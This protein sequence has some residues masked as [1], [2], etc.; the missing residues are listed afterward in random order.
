MLA[1]IMSGAVLGIEAYLVEVEVDISFGLTAF[2]IVGLPD[3]AVRE[4]RLRIPSALENAGHEMPQKKIT[5]NL[6]PA[7]IRK[8]GTAFDL[9]MAV[10]VLAAYGAI[11]QECQ[12]FKLEEYLLVG[13]L[14]LNGE[15]RSIR[16]ALSLAVMAR[17]EGLRG[18][19]LPQENAAEAAVVSD[20]EVIGVRHLKEVT[21][22]IRGELALEPAVA[23]LRPA[24]D[25]AP[26]YRVDFSEV[27]GQESVKRALEVAAAG[28]HNVLLIGPPG[29][30]KSMLA[31]R[32]PTILPGMTFEEA[33]E[34]TKIYSVT[35]Q[36]GSDE[37]LIL[38]RPFRG[39]H[40]TISDV[41]LV[42][43]GSGMPR[44]GE[45]SLA[46]NGVLFLDEVPEF[47]RNA[48]EVMRQPLED[49]CVTISRSLMTLNY[50]ANI[51]L[52]AAMNP[53]P[54]GY[55]GGSKKKCDCGQEKVRDYRNRISGPLL[56]RID[57]HVEVP[58]VPYRKLKAAGQGETSAAI[59]ARVQRAREVQRAR[60]AG[61]S[62]YAN[63]QMRPSELRAHCK[64]D[65]A[66][67]DLMEMVVDR[68]GM[69]ARAYDRILKVA[70]TVADLEGKANIEASHIAEAIQYRSMDRGLGEANAA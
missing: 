33:L 48:L 14:N 31:K 18:I 70:R 61:G 46:H 19:I 11:P 21:A 49:G 41:G 54:C 16:G 57:I 24:D 9:P 30:G 53:C 2:R 28:G 50:P 67:H 59:Q 22:Y 60:F 64:I 37:G 43:G 52:I 39:P 4:S 65:A 1:R 44:P 27:A 7:D 56:D 51:M 55:F 42:G 10:G 3:G 32:I 12:S 69:S 26:G 68:L 40:H 62:T 8:D 58:A 15:V 38:R 23:E 34:T 13:E 29:S 36:L 66:G 20:I 25:L 17:D 45:V 5:V 6:A 63:S 47:R 35:G